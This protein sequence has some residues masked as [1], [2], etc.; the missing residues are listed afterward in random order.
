MALGLS[1]P[2]IAT[3]VLIALQKRSE[4]KGF[5]FFIMGFFSQ[6]ISIMIS[7]I[8]SILPYLVSRTIPSADIFQAVSAIHRGVSL[9][10]YSLFYFFLSL[11]FL[12]LLGYKTR[13][14]RL[15]VTSALLSAISLFVP[16]FTIDT[17]LIAPTYTFPLEMSLDFLVQL[18]LTIIVTLLTIAVYY[19]VI[20]SVFNGLIGRILILVGGIFVFAS[21][22]TYFPI[23]GSVSPWIGLVL[24]LISALVACFA[25]QHH[26]KE[27]ERTM[28]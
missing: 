12:S 17:K 28:S 23:L 7:A 22:F 18:A 19:F 15:A 21:P 6:I 9:F 5:K 16:W 14:N 27:L 20:G 24:P 13:V 2:V 4:I 3:A 8:L 11:G 26:P 25:L 1:I 10:L